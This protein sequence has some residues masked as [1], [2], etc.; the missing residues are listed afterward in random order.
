MRLGGECPVFRIS[1]WIPLS[2]SIVDSVQSLFDVAREE[3]NLS[4]SDAT[5]E[6]VA[7]IE[8]FLISTQT[9]LDFFF[10][11]SSCR[12]V[13][14]TGNAVRSLRCASDDKGHPDKTSLR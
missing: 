12:S 6:T 9:V 10:D 3:D 4:S 7:S 2:H 1:I 13:V 11:D 8:F 5:W 14:S